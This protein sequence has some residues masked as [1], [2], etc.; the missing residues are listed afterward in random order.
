MLD[1]L[2]K[3]QYLAKHHSAI[4]C[5]ENGEHTLNFIPAHNGEFIIH[6]SNF[7]SLID[8]ALAECNK[9]FEKGAI[10]IA[11]IDGHLEG[12]SPTVLTRNILQR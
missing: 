11:D 6:N 2:D 9:F 10:A 7:E 5:F 4:Y 12:S 3:L 1:T 8:E